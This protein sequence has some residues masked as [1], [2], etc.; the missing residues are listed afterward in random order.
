MRLDLGRIRII[1]EIEKESTKKEKRVS[2]E[3][4]K[5]G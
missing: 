2:E 3:E 1:E 5:G 4:Q